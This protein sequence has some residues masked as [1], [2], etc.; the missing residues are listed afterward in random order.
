MS[1]I[2]SFLMLTLILFSCSHKVIRTGYE[3]PHGH[4]PMPCVVKFTYEAR[5]DSSEA[6]FKGTIKLKESGFSTQC[7]AEDAYRIIRIEACQLG[8]NIAII[9]DEKMPNL[10]STCYRCTADL[11]AIDSLIL[12]EN[13]TQSDWISNEAIESTNLEVK[14]KSKGLIWGGITGGLI[15]G[16]VAGLSSKK[17]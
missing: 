4:I 14:K 5:F 3:K 7:N 13:Y 16:L 9:R 6:V 2:L 11:Y 8:A 1:K 15:G 10:A 17:R 12:V